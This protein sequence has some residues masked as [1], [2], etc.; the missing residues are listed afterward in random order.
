MPLSIKLKMI[1]MKC[2]KETGHF[3]MLMKEL[4]SQCSRIREE[5]IN[6]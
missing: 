4:T 5:N 6:D 2:E 1:I 3:L